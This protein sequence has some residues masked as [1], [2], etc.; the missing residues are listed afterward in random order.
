MKDKVKYLRQGVRLSGLDTDT[1]N[2]A[3]AN[4]GNVAA[5][6]S[7]TVANVLPSTFIDAD[8]HGTHIDLCNRIFTS[9]QEGNG[10]DAVPLPAEVDP[11]GFLAKLG[12]DN[13]YYG[14][15]NQVSY[16]ERRHN[17][18]TGKKRCA[19]KRRWRE[20]Q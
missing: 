2:R 4:I 18:M 8:E 17:R 20:N 3:I 14:E 7:R 12:G 16:L 19:H 10:N 13:Y 1:F 6:F 5:M 9:R 11:T 15:E